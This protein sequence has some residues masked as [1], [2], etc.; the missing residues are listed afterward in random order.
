MHIGLLC[1]QEDPAERPTMSSAV[2]LLGNEAIT[3]PEPKHP[4]LAVRGVRIQ[5]DLLLST[6]PS[7]NQLTDSGFS[8]R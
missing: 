5:S 2:V 3:L 8:A 6:N 1:V 4:A 7:M